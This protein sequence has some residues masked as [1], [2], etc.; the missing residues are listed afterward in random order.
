MHLQL[1]NTPKLCATGFLFAIGVAM[2]CMLAESFPQLG[3][4]R[5]VPGLDNGVALTLATDETGLKYFASFHNY[6]TKPL[7]L[8]IGTITANDKWRC[9]SRI[10]LLITG[11]NG[12]ARH[13]ESSLGCNP[14]GVI[15]GRM[16]AL[17]IPLAAGAV[18]SLPIF[19]PRGAAPGRYLVKARYTGARIPLRFCNLDM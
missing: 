5:S 9:P 15:G 12:K 18:Y 8:V 6:L 10:E 13:R 14:S 4:Y 19:D 1:W 11:P 3:H 7:F 2:G 17:I 16:D